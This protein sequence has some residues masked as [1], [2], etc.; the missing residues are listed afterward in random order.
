MR[1]KRKAAALVFPMA[2]A[3]VAAVLLGAS[4]AKA[5]AV[6]TFV[7]GQGADSGAC[8]L[9]S[10]CRSFAYAITQTAAGGEIA[11]LNTAGYGA[12]AIGQAISIVNPGGVEAGISAVSGGT[13]ITINAGSSDTVAL[14]GLTLEGAG[15]GQTG[16]A[17]SGG[18][19]LEIIDCVVRDFTVYGIS[20]DT[21]SP[22]NPATLSVLISRTFALNSPGDGILLQT[23]GPTT[24]SLD[25]V[26]TANNK[27]GIVVSGASA[28]VEA[29]ISD[30]HIDNNTTTGIYLI[31]ESTGSGNVIVQNS[32]I[33]QT[34]TGISLNG[35]S[36]LW[37]S[38]VTQSAVPGITNTGI[39][40]SGTNNIVY[41]D[42]TSHFNLTF[43]PQPWGFQ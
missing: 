7:S 29:L 24:A 3:L 1:T 37:L 27:F 21:S 43:T 5:Q 16:I 6:R 26:T 40:E 33:N 14:R 15:V 20:V 30:S 4:P 25:Q 9:A 32:T 39:A 41:S 31:G 17:F 34:P 2:V 23:G 36:T 35:Y 38:N 10:P 13:A 18:A 19:R 28:L 8:A 11:V 22:P 12:V 42:G